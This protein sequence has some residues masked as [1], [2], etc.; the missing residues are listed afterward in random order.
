[1]RTELATMASLMAV[2]LVATGGEARDNA[3]TVI[4]PRLIAAA[5]IGQPGIDSVKPNPLNNVYFGEQHLP[6]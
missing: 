6:R 4:A 5:S 2:I 1:M 3:R